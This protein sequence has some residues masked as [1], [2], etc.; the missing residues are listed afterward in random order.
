MF[1]G[2]VLRHPQIFS[3]GSSEVTAAHPDVWRTIVLAV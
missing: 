2:E 1:G 3:E